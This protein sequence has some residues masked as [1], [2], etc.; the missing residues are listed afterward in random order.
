MFVSPK[1]KDFPGLHDWIHVQRKEYKK[2][3]AGDAKALMYDSW[4]AKLEAVGFDWAPR[5]GEGFKNIVLS[6]RA[7]E[8]DALWTEHYK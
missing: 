5:S 6:R 1:D 7:E 3:R 4:V 2:W 8:R